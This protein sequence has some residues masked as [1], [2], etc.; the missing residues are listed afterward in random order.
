MKTISVVAAI[1]EYQGKVLC[2]QR[3][4]N[5]HIYISEKWEFPGGKVE[6]G[7]SEQQALARE[8]Q[9]ELLIEIRVG[10]KLLAVDH[11]Y[12]DFRLVMHSY[13]CTP[14][15]S[16]MPEITLTE[17]LSLRWLEIGSK[18]FVE[19]DWAAA[20]VPIVGRLCERAK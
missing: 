9:E 15:S 8:I 4:A 2:V 20:D 13:L 16:G 5:K 6:D 10:E 11:T 12:P 7:E 17:H 19:L 1:I 3:A 18:D 14:R